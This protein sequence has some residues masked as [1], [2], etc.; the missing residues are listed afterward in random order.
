MNC[1]LSGR[2]VRVFGYKMFMN[3]Q[4]TSK[5]TVDK[6]KFMR[7]TDNTPCERRLILENDTETRRTRGSGDHGRFRKNSQFENEF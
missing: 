1:G 3:S 2:N 7:Y 5:K 6:R 4:K